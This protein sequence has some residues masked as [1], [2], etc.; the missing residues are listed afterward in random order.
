[1]SGLILLT[2]VVASLWLCV[3][4]SKTIGNLV[5]NA[6]WRSAVKVGVFLALLASPFVDELIGMYQFKA[7]CKA[8]GIESA[9]VSKARG[10]RVKV[11]YSERTD[12]EPRVLLPTKESDV[13]FRDADTA[14]ILIRHKNYY[15]E[16]GWLMRHTPISMG[17]HT[18]MLFGGLC[19]QRK[20]QEIFQANSITFLY[21]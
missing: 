19:D 18:P 12:V 10:N 13:T 3:W 4:L 9:D 7:L 20:E 1:M 6:A 17:N 2:A 11:Q 8:N 5:P 16:G 15:S 21:K 14:E